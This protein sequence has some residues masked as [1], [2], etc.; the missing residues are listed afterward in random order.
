MKKREIRIWAVL[1]WLIIWQIAAM[2]LDQE[3][4]LVSPWRA[5]LRFLQLAGTTAFWLAALGSTLRIAAGFLLAFVCGAGC[6]YLA[7]RFRRVRE[8]MTP[9]V[10]V[11]KAVPVASFVILA[12]ICFS[13]RYLAVLISFLIVF[14]LIYASTLAGIGNVDVRMLEMGK[15]FRLDRPT[16]FRYIYLPALSAFL[17][18]ALR[19]AIGMAWKAG[20]AA[21]VIGTPRG[22]IG[23]K[24]QQ[25]KVYLETPDLIA[26]TLAIILLSILTEKLVMFL[27][28]RVE[29]LWQTA[30]AADAAGT[31]RT[32]TG[33]EIGRNSAEGLTGTGA[34]VVLQD[35]G[36]SFDGKDVLRD[37]NLTAAP[38][39]TIAV[40]AP[41]GAGK[42]TLIRLIA[43]LEK[44]DAGS[45]RVRKERSD[46]QWKESN[47]R[48]KTGETGKSPARIAGGEPESPARIAGGEPESPARIAM[49]FQEDRL[50]EDLD[51][52]GNIRL[53]NRALSDKEIAVAAAEIGLTDVRGKETRD[54]SGGMK[55]RTAL[56]RALL[57]ESEVLLLDEPFGGLDA[58]TKSLAAR[59][60]RTRGAGKTIILVTHE[61]EEAELLAAGR[62]VTFAKSS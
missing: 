32:G 15:V 52:T 1:A 31:A 43:G 2:V 56:L 19:T 47:R 38:R 6:A 42:T 51:A 10:A 4:F 61:K 49:V 50:C 3:I 7:A 9:L 12:L 40:M 22:S 36:K 26:W 30:P 11:I 59:F 48:E 23:A 8:L 46:R 39:E 14:P 53:A 33:G 34:F 13:S 37:F 25:A 41:S 62:I 54:F 57:A 16:L 45:V 27:L 20:T 55:R 35:V 17:T 5:F 58:A 28:T 18:P 21:E 60:V 44:P 29:K 24:L